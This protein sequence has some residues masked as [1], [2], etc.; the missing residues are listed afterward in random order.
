MKHFLFALF[1]TTACSNGDPTGSTCPTTNAPTYASFGQQ[2]FTTYCTSCHSATS[3]NRH[4]APKSQNY[5]TEDD[6][7]RHAADIDQAAA[8]G[9]DATNTSMPQLG[10]TV[11]RK[12]TDAEREMLG[13]YL[14]CLMN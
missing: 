13:Q 10:G 2:F 1:L 8:K 12:P 11:S 3:T 9:P 6:V 4:G 7:I 14:S 5:D